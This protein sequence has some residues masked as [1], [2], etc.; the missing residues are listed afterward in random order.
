MLKS[1][2]SETEVKMERHWGPEVKVPQSRVEKTNPPRINDVAKKPEDSVKAKCLSALDQWQRWGVVIDYD[3]VSGL[4]RK[5]LPN[6]RWI[7][8]TKKGKRDLIAW[9]KVG[10]VLWSYLIEVKAP[11]QVQKPE[12]LEYEAKWKG[13][14]NVIYEVVEHYNQIDL[15]LDRLTGRTARLL[16]EAGEHM[17]PVKKGI[18]LKVRKR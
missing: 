18:F 7:M 8:N 16:Q 1:Q 4:G 15:T 6:G 14:E 5:M 11:G 10:K 9:F 13:L 12:Q 3:D 17:Y 2:Q